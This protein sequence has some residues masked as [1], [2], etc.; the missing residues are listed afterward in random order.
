MPTKY[1]TIQI[2]LYFLHPKIKQ[3]T[4]SKLNKHCGNCLGFLPPSCDIHDDCIN[5]ILI[6]IY[7]IIFS[8]IQVQSKWKILRDGFTRYCRTLKKKS[9]S[10]ASTVKQYSTFYDQ[11]LFLKDVTEDKGRSTSNFDTPSQ[12]NPLPVRPL[13]EERDQKRQRKRQSDGEDALIL[14]LTKKVNDKLEKDERDSSPP[15]DEDKS[16]LLSLVS[17]RNGD[18]L[19]VLTF[20]YLNGDCSGYY[21]FSIKFCLKYTSVFFTGLLSR[22][23]KGGLFCI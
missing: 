21:N 12:T 10:A 7:Y 15:L 22:C 23:I 9:G 3:I 6:I 14:K 20:F 8:G 1:N 11:L 4:I 17:D 16:F 2:Y 5:Y 18:L 13:D 19:I